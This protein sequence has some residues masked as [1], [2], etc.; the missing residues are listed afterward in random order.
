M[1]SPEQRF[2]AAGVTLLGIVIVVQERGENPSAWL[3]LG[4][5]LAIALP[6]FVDGRRARP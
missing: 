5:C 6:V 2:L 1:P 3:W 4:L